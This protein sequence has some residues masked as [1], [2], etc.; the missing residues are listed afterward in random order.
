MSVRPTV[1][2]QIESALSWFRRIYLQGIPFLLRQNETA[3]LSFVCVVAAID[4]LAGYRYANED[5]RG[6]FSRFIREYFPPEYQP[7][8]DNLY[9]FRCRL[10]HNFSPAH[11]S[12]VH[13]ASAS[14]LQASAIGDPILDDATFFAHMQS[15]AE[16]YFSDLSANSTLQSSM[17]ARLNNLS[18]GGAI[19]VTRGGAG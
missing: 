9:V 12:L 4:A 11:F 14:H 19:G 13:G 8:A 16:R 7:H 10:L 17:Q 15:A 5:D 2:P 1:D 3:F 6:R 18:R